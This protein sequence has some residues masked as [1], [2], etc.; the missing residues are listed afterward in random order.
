MKIGERIIVEKGAT[1]TAPFRGDY[2]A[3]TILSGEIK[4]RFIA[5]NKI[6]LNIVK[7]DAELL[8]PFQML[9]RLDKGDTI[10]LEY[11]TGD[12]WKPYDDFTVTVEGGG[13]EVFAPG[14]YG[15]TVTDE[16]DN[17]CWG[18]IV[19]EDKLPPVINCQDL[20]VNC[21]ELVVADP[22][23][24][25]TG[26]TEWSST[27]G[28]AKSAGPVSYRQSWQTSPERRV[29]CRSPNAK[30]CSPGPAQGY[31]ASGAGAARANLPEWQ[32]PGT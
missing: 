18:V 32:R 21:L 24:G 22:A 16:N 7:L 15:V 27:P 14:T 17:D 13:D 26:L 30:G 31:P 20:E 10:T 2:R 19:V 25:Y 11:W 23:P 8:L 1:F 4:A 6:H 29:P 9:A 3:D 5:S 28:S 12:D